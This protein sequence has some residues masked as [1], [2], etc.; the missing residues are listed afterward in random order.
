MNKIEALQGFIRDNQSDLP[1]SYSL[2]SIKDSGDKEVVTHR[3]VPIQFYGTR[4][5]LVS[6]HPKPISKIYLLGASNE[7]KAF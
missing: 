3:F 4:N 1:V 7:K 6:P 2:L 5:Y